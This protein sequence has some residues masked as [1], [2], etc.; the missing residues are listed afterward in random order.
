MPPAALP[1]RLVRPLPSCD[2]ARRRRPARHVRHDD[3]ERRARRARGA[4]VRPRARPDGRHRR[5][6]D[7]AAGQRGGAR[8]RRPLR[9]GGRGAPAVRRRGPRGRRRGPGA[10]RRARAGPGAR[11]LPLPGRAPRRRAPLARDA[12]RARPRARAPARRGARR[13]RPAGGRRGAPHRRL[14]GRAAG[15]GDRGRRGPD[16]AR[17]PRARADPRGRDGRAGSACASRTWSSGAT[18][19]ARGRPSAWPPTTRTARERETRL[20]RP[21]GSEAVVLISAT[22]VRDPRD[23]PLY[24]VS[25]SSTSRPERA[26]ARPGSRRNEAKLAEAQQIARLGS[27][28]WEIASDHVVWSD[29]LYRIYGV[30]PDRL[31]GSYGSYLDKVHE[32]DRARV[33]RVIET[34]V[35]ERRRMVAGLPDRPPRPGDA[36]GPRARRGRAR[37][38]GPPGDRAR[39]R[40]GRHGEPPGRGRAAGRR[41]ALPPRLRRRADR[42]GAHRPRRPLAAPEPRAVADARAQRAGA[43]ARSSSPRSATPPTSTSTGRC[44]KEL[45]AGRRRSYAIERRLHARRRARHQHAHARLAHARRR[46]AAAVLPLPARRHHRA[47]P[48]R[49]RAPRHAGPAAGDHRQLADADLH[50]GPRAAVPARQP[51]VG[52]AV[53]GPEGARAPPPH[54]GG[55]AAGAGARA[56]GDGPRGHRDRRAARVARRGRRP[57]RRGGPPPPAPPEV[58]AARRRGPDLRR[59]LDRDRRHRARA[60]DAGSARSSSGAS[61]SPSAWSRS[62]SSRAASR[63]TSTTCSR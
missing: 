38:P 41:A 37:R 62:D 5:R 44:C 52:G 17:Q 40:P 13:D 27:W 9:G 59:L 3:H 54:R 4:P 56:R 14:H 42:H 10:L 8:A 43:S 2:G 39:H 58:P 11:A 63:T 18:W 60:L 61:R 19:A 26:E 29:E 53:R 12:D 36:D 35:A 48:G 34:A 1:R 25:R 31:P 47:P 21:D 45:L 50:Q 20:R 55:H 49:G 6:R 33:A 46:R 22:L 51:A 24:Y 57:G 7:R 16:R 30:R 32:D 28:E 15:H 23:V